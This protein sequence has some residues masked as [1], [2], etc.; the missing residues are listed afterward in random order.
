MIELWQ[1]F[2]W[3]HKLIV[4]TYLVGV[5]IQCA[6]NIARSPVWNG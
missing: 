4:I 6:L 5:I 2:K 1:E 3:Y